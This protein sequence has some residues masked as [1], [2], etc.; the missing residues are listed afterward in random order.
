MIL[1][2]SQ[3]SANDLLSSLGWSKPGDLTLNE[4]ALASNALVKESNLEGSEGVISIN[5]DEAIIT[6][7]SKQNYEPRK[8]FVLA[9]E[10]GHLILH[11]D[12]SR[13][14]S[15]TNKTLNEWYTKGKH[16]VEANQFA[17]ELLMPSHLF[18]S[19]VAGEVMNLDLI[20]TTAEYFGTSITATL[21]KYK[22]LGD[23]P[24][25]VIFL[26]NGIVHWKQESSDFPLKFLA[27]GSQVPEGSVAADYYNGRGLEE[28]PV[29]VDALDWFPE[30]FEIED[31]LE[32]QF[33]EYC[34]KIGNEGL[35]SC[36][37]AQ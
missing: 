22:D 28:E 33:F 34:F 8:R 1:T 15:D 21:L 24:L 4:I 3:K 29:L 19:K 6:I 37:W 10:I 14:F 31:H 7:D 27:K 35:L 26:K 17:S 9:H 25:S 18:K 36:L 13:L 11:K 16:E 30:D 32:T 20:N 2:N 23:F 12:I 5:G